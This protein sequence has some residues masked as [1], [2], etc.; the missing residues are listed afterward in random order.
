MKPRPILCFGPLHRW[1]LGEY[2][3]VLPN[4]VTVIYSFHCERCHALAGIGI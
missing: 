2:R 3:V 1:I 4:G